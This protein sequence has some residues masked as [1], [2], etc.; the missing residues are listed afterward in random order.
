M[1]DKPVT[2]EQ[3]QNM[4]ELVIRLDN[5][6]KI[7]EAQISNWEVDDYYER[8]LKKFDTKEFGF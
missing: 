5:Q 4:R 8:N 7:D 2:E 3:I 1:N 6:K